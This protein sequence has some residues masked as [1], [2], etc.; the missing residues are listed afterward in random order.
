MQNQKDTRPIMVAI[1]CITYNHEPYIRQCLEGFVMQRTNFRFV[2]IVHDDASTDGT[3]AIIREYEE[4]YPDIIRPIYETENKYSKRDGSLSKIMNEAIDATHCKYVALC[5]GDDY[6]IDENKLQMQ[7]DFL[8]NHLDYS[9][10]SHR[11]KKYYH[12]QQV[13]YVDRLDKMFA[14][15]EGR[16]YTNRSKVWLSETSSVVYRYVADIEFVKYPYSGIDVVHMYFLLKHGRGFC[17]SKVMSIYRQHAGGVFSMRNVN[18]Q[19]INGSYKALK[20][21]YNFQKTFDSRCL[22]YGSYANVFRLTKGRILF[23]EKFS[24]GKFLCLPFFLMKMIIGVHP[25]YKREEF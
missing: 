23:M 1:N 21:L 2:A 9:V 17:L 16:E 12:D 18:D 6:W 7:V 14:N 11:I 10:C 20:Q 24:I 5:E 3:A 8:E 13:F 19:F 22:Y 25:V 15:R 4:K